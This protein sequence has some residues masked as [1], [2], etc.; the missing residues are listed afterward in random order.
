M[1]RFINWKIYR[2][3]IFGFFGGL[4]FL[5]LGTWLETNR[6]RLPFTLESFLS[7]HTTSPMIIMLDLAPVIFAAMIGLIGLQRN[8]QSTIAIRFPLKTEAYSVNGN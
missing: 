7:L 5:F 1:Q 4:C 6:Y 3:F 8:L 2:F